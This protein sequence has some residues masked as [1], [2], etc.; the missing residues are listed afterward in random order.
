[1]AFRDTRRLA[2]VSKGKVFVAE[3]D[4]QV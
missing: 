4:A 2:N 3:H 1:M